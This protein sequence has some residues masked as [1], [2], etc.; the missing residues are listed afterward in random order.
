MFRDTP[1]TKLLIPP[2]IRHDELRP[3]LLQDGEVRGRGK[4]GDDQREQEVQG[5]EQEEGR[6][7][8]GATSAERS[9]RQMMDALN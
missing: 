6:E 2:F 8:R 4:H 7:R 5:G 1:K 9:Q 3:E